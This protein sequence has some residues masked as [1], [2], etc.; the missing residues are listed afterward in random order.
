MRW[1]TQGLLLPDAVAFT[2]SSQLGR[3]WRH[4]GQLSEHASARLAS[5]S[6]E[7]GERVVA[8]LGGVALG[9]SSGVSAALRP[10]E[11]GDVLVTRDVAA[12]GKA[13]RVLNGE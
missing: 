6:S 9:G 12:L 3:A 2:D 8:P 11:N 13:V 5:S 7:A 4:I 10:N 1:I